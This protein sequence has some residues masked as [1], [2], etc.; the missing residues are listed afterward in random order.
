MT[1]GMPQTSLARGAVA[2]AA[3]G[4][5]IAALRAVAITAGIVWSVL[6]IVV[7]LAC[8]LQQYG[9]GSMFSYAVAVE[10][11]LYIYSDRTTVK[12]RNI[13]HDDRVSINLPDGED[14]VIV[15]GRLA[16][17]GSPMTRP[18]VV[19][20]IVAKY[21]EPMDLSA[22]PSEDPDAD[23]VLWSLAPTR[24]WLWRLDD[25]DGSQA[26]WSAS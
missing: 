1:A 22:L 20:A 2:H 21:T 11:V 9:D 7:G 15:H 10:D 17:L 4:P 12:S 25:W 23:E 24:A 8:R 13:A 6:F 16:D 14:V 5:R 18:D 3:A 26:R 19:A